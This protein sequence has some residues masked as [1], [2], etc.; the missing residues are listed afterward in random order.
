MLKKMNYVRFQTNQKKYML[1]FCTQR[2]TLY[3]FIFFICKIHN[4]NVHIVKLI[5][6][7][8]YVLKNSIFYRLRNCKYINIYIFVFL[9]AKSGYIQTSLSKDLILIIIMLSSK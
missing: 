6:I 3:F 4:F 2:G 8:Y 7:L 5:V 1:E 9:P